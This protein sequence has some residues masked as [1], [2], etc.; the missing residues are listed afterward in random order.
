L[1]QG[2]RLNCP[3]PTYPSTSGVDTAIAVQR[4]PA[5]AR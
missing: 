3:E 4:I 1:R 5:L 2:K